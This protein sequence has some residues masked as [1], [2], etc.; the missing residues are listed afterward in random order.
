MDY[1]EDFLTQLQSDPYNF[2]L[3]G[4][5]PGRYWVSRNGQKIGPIYPFLIFKMIHIKENIKT[6]VYKALNLLKT[7]DLYFLKCGAS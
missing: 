5:G 4:L 2:K 6:S 3:K 1:P 7:D